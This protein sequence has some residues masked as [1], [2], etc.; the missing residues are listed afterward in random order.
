MKN[1]I[2]RK[3]HSP[4]LMIFFLMLAVGCDNSDPESIEVNRL[5]VP[6]THPALYQKYLQNLRDYKASRHNI[7]MVSFDNHLKES[8]S[9]AH[10]IDAIPDSVDYVS[11][12]YPGEL[13]DSETKQIDDVRTNKGTKFIFTIHYDSIDG[14]YRQMQSKREEAIKSLKEGAEKPKELPSFENYLTDTLQ[15]SLSLM[16]KFKYDGI[17]VGYNGKS[18]RH[19]TDIETKEYSEHQN[20]FIGIL[21]DWYSRNSN[22]ELFFEGKPQNLLDKSLLKDCKY[23]IIPNT[24]SSSVNKLDYTIRLANVEGVPSDRY[25]VAVEMTSLDSADEKTGYWVDEKTAVQG[26]ALYVAS[27]HESYHTIGLGVYHAGNDYYFS[28]EES[29]QRIYDKIRSAINIIN[30]SIKK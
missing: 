26:A 12:M 29:H 16:G 3:K 24:E 7:M 27:E 20:I 11:L 1:I 6:E 25:I 28:K 14:K 21:K 2:K 22:K 18:T 15:Y 10:H 4:L 30:P 23:L 19:L 8:T 17:C 9:A 13:S 5:G